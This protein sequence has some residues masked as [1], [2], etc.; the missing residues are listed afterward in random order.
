MITL[1]HAALLLRGNF[2]QIY[3]LCRWLLLP[4]SFTLRSVLQNRLP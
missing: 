4:L 2:E 3:C 1:Q